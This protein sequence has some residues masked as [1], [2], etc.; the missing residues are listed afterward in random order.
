MVCTDLKK[1]KFKKQKKTKRSMALEP[2]FH[3]WHSL[4]EECTW[5]DNGVIGKT[6]AIQ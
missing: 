3:N 4:V 1:T 5:A 2:S 6:T